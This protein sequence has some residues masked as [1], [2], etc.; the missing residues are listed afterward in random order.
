MPTQRIGCG[1]LNCRLVNETTKEN[2]NGPIV[3]RKGTATAGPTMIRAT[4]RSCCLG[5]TVRSSRFT[6]HGWQPGCWSGKG[7]LDYQGLW[8]ISGRRGR[9]GRSGLSARP[10]GRHLVADTPTRPYADTPL[11]A[12]GFWLL[13]P[14]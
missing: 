5:V 8:L 11:L 6:V 12:P 10:N 3:I 13:A 7:S 14:I 1:A 9:S 2:S 4:V